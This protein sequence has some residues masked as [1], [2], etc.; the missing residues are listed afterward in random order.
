MAKADETK[1]E[2]KKRPK[3][4]DEADRT[5]KENRGSKDSKESKKGKEDK[6]INIAYTYTE[7]KDQ[8]TGEVIWNSMKD[9]NNGQ[10]KDHRPGNDSQ[11]ASTGSGQGKEK[12]KDKNKGKGKKSSPFETEEIKSPMFE[13]QKF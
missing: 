12:D 4:K 2:N 9:H 13:I 8:N 5:D 6:K 7:I 10:F 1:K 11:G 3:W